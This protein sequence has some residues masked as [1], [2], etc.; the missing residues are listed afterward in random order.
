MAGVEDKCRCTP[1]DHA[2]HRRRL[3]GP[4]LDRIDLTVRVERP[5]ASDF[6]RPGL[7]D[8]ATERARVIAARGRQLARLEGTAATCNAHLDAA[9]SRTYL[10]LSDAAARVLHAAYDDGKLSGRGRLRVLRIAR[11]IADLD[12][13]ER[14][15]PRHVK[16]AISLHQ[17]DIALEEAS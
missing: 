15:A 4:L 7:H 9:L 16:Q 5:A 10:S 2:R 6:A 3:S 12:S 17:P 13:D 14:V 8:S 11:T 1:L